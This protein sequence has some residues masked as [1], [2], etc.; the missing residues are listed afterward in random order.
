[1]GEERNHE[2]CV[3][4]SMNVATYA[5]KFPAQDVGHIWDVVVRKSGMELTSTSQMVNGIELPRY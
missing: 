3:A 4:N 5:K 2:I 1:M